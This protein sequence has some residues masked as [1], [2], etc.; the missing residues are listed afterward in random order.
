MLP[1][2]SHCMTT[3]NGSEKFKDV[4]VLQLVSCLFCWENESRNS[5]NT[6]KLCLFFQMQASSDPVSLQSYVSLS[7]T[8]FGC[9]F[10]KIHL[11]LS[12]HFTFISFLFCSISCNLLLRHILFCF[13]CM[14]N[15]HQLLLFFYPIWSNVFVNFSCP[16]RMSKRFSID[17]KKKT[18]VSSLLNYERCI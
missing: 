17:L 9:N 5:A 15:S 16:K 6:G 8:L 12:V 18:V 10:T 3:Q 13:A 2:F 4:L 7:F 11:F 14:R 1:V